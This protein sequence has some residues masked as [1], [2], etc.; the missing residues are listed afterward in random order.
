MNYNNTSNVD[1]DANN[2]IHIAPTCDENATNGNGGNRNVLNLT[3]NTQVIKD[4]HISKNKRK[5]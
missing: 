3:G 2:F 5:N 1:D 4:N